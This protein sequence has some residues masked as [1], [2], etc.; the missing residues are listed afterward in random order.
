MPDK[1]KLSVIIVTWNSESEIGDCINSLSQGTRDSDFEIIVIDND[2]KD[3][4][5]SILSDLSSQFDSLKII[6]NSENRGF[7]EA[8]NQ[9]IAAA[10]GELIFL[11]NPDTKTPDGAIRKLAEKLES[12][13]SAGAIAPQLLNEDHSIQYSCR[14]FPGYYDMF[15]ELTL[16]ST[17]FPRSRIFARWKMKY[18]SH[19]SERVVDQPMAAALM[20]KKRVM[21]KVGNFDSRFKMFFNDVDLCKKISDEGYGI[22][23]FPEAKI[24]HGKGKSIYKDRIRMINVWNED[25]L[26]Y[27][28]K[29]HY[30]FF[31]YNWL[32][33][34]L[35]ISG[36]L[37]ILIHKILK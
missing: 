31:L 10:E 7:T 28:R 6:L 25:C 11:L 22:I 29:Y 24:V 12:N 37:R 16:L 30:N 27:F 2:S 5:R 8:C 4:T 33:L 35:K 32:S 13:D 26:K 21:K 15:C 9:G 23:F 3:S 14:T 20:V 1:K 34:S 19:D 17:F 18:F 36:M